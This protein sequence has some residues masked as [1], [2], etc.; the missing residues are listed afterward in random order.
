MRV[1]G[2]HI[3]GRTMS[4]RLPAVSLS[5]ALLVL[6]SLCQPSFVGPA[7]AQGTRGSDS[8]GTWSEF[9][10]NLNNTG[11][12]VASI[13]RNYGVSLRI[14]TSSYFHSSA[15][16]AG[17]MLFFGSDD[18]KVHAFNLTKGKE[19]WNYTTNS[20]V[21]ATPLIVGDRVFIGSM[22][23]SMYALNRRN[24]SL[25]WSFATN[26]SISSSAKYIDG[27]VVF[28]SYDGNVYF[29]NATTGLEAAPAFKTDGQIWGTPAI[30]NGTIIIGSNDGNVSR[31]RMSD[32]SIVWKFPLPMQWYG[33]VKYSSAA[34]YDGRVFINSDDHSAYALNLET[35]ALVW[36]FETGAAVYAS[37]GVYDGKVFVHSVDGNLYALPFDDPN[38]DG[39]ISRNE[40]LWN[41]TTGDGPEGDGGGSSPAI[42]GGKVFVATRQGNF[43]CID[44]SS[45]QRSWNYSVG[46]RYPSFSSPA[47]V[48]G[49]VFVG[50]SDGFMYGFSDLALGMTVEIAPAKTVVESLKAMEV[51]VFVNYS[52]QPVEGA[53]VSIAV[54]LGTLS[55][56]FASTLAD[57]MQR[58]KYMPPQVGQQTIVTI[59]ANATKYPLA[60][61]ESQVSITVVPAQE[62]GTTSG[63]AF[64]FEKYQ[65][66]FFIIA[67]LVVANVVVYG[68]IIIRKRRG[69]T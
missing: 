21:Y 18:W 28:A 12:S 29:L 59:T 7:A 16:L 67:A 68:A 24:G 56:N 45:G 48:D 30:V 46:S 60:P 22:D 1:L 27:A 5:S 49:K 31:I 15:V 38:H 39:N 51:L 26:D 54:S 34:V 41:F 11:Y 61:A 47:V 43:F 64:S 52:G 63:S 36:K 20:S 62:Y 19:A 9:R 65:L 33:F 57:G 23:S 37:P 44:E 69:S 6:A 50:L 17:D 14:N 8:A 55:Q 66:F 58:V 35:G 40:V 3:E 4:I 10:G 13:P 25:L 2:T 42:A 53:G 32:H